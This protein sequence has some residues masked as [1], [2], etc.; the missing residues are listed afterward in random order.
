M[1]RRVSFFSA[2]LVLFAFCVASAQERPGLGVMDINPLD[3]D[4]RSLIS[5]SRVISQLVRHELA[6][7]GAFEIVERE[8]VQ[9]ILRVQ[10]FGLT[11]CTSD[12]CLIEI[13]R[14][15]N[16]PKMAVG[17]LGRLGRKYVLTL[18]IIDVEL[19]IWDSQ[20][21]EAGI[22][23]LE[24]LDKLVRPLVDKV[25][26]GRE[27]PAR[28]EEE[29]PVSPEEKRPPEEKPAPLT[30]KETRFLISLYYS[31]VYNSNNS[32]LVD[33]EWE[34]ERHGTSAYGLLQRFQGEGRIWWG[35]GLALHYHIAKP[36][37]AY[38]GELRSI[39]SFVF[40]TLGGPGDKPI[41]FHL[42][43][44]VGV[45]RVRLFARVLAYDP[46]S[47]RDVFFDDDTVQLRLA[48]MGAGAVSLRL[49]KRFSISAGVQA[50]GCN[51]DLGDFRRGKY[52]TGYGHPSVVFF[53]LQTGLVFQL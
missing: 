10:G 37:D 42:K 44:G 53:S 17:T 4:D 52:E 23:E 50:H 30:K 47:L 16:A 3:P 33:Y 32:G 9:D 45:M 38:R 24:E 46:D 13:G 48:Q 7:T 21:T 36:T 26:Y 15:L 12:S 14:L 11:G 1:I 22:Y 43:F 2:V 6:A 35:A 29:R 18:R 40:V 28:G 34:K 8:R 49:S 41:Q 25:V 5:A 27:V 19:G 20:G 39:G 31:P 51:L